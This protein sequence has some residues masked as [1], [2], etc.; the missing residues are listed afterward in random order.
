M[1][2]KI[3]IVLIVLAF[4]A[5]G[6]E[7][8]LRN[9]YGFCD[10]VLLQEDPDFEYIAQPDQ[11]RFRYRN[12]I[13]YNSNS[14]RSEEVDTTANIILGFGDSIINGGMQTDNDALATTILSDTL[15]KIQGRK[16]QFLNVSAESWGPDNAFEYLNKYGDFG[17]SA[18]FLFVSSHDAHDTMTFEKIVDT[19]ESYPSKQYSL[20]LIELLDRYLLPRVKGMLAS[21]TSENDKL[22]ITKGTGF[23]QG[24]AS[25][26]SYAKDHNLPLT[27]YLH[28]E[29]GEL[30]A[31][32]YNQDGQEIIQFAKDN[33][34][35]IILDLENGLSSSY[36]R[37][38]IHINPEGQKKM[39]ETVV[40]YMSEG[41]PGRITPH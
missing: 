18:M 33:N 19:N 6:T 17:A 37:D 41:Q 28:A 34:I 8:F 5:V 26:L 36:F 35:P 16:V 40:K 12:H 31:G 11:E 30:E 38:Y 4:C 7:L 13:R 25:F 22:A 29:T 2:K 39:A 14:M 15:T 21:Q 10:A 9:Y 20:A 23:N 27:I 32:T 24:F 1:N 3:T